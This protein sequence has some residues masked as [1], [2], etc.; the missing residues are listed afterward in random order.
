MS[1]FKEYL[2]EN[3][4]IKS[5]KAKSRGLTHINYG[6]YKDAKGTHW[7]YDDKKSDFVVVAHHVGDKRVPISKEAEDK[8]NAPKHKEDGLKKE[9]EQHRSRIDT[10]KA[11]AKA[12]GFHFSGSGLMGDDGAVFTKG[13]EDDPYLWDDKSRK[14]IK[15]P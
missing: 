7:K 9:I 1:K 10:I 3:A 14:F 5:A 4:D 2:L 6:V 13:D 8:F 15:H 12:Q 11:A